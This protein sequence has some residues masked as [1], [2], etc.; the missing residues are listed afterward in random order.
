MRLAEDVERDPVRFQGNWI[1]HQIRTGDGRRHLLRRRLRR[2]L[3]AARPPRASARRCTSAS[4]AAASCAPWSRA[5]STKAEALRRYHDFS[6]AHA[7][8]FDWL[9]RVQWLVPRVPPRLLHLGLRRSRADG[10]SRWAFERYLAIA[11]PEF[12]AGAAGELRRGGPGRGP[13][14]LR[15]S[16]SSAPANGPTGD[17]SR[18]WIHRP[19]LTARRVPSARVDRRGSERLAAL[20]GHVPGHHRVGLARAER[21]DEPS[22]PVARGHASARPAATRRTTSGNPAPPR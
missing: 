10:V 21:S 8:E 6:A 11:P 20:A 1:P 9:L 3:R 19:S 4:P 22:R 16:G 15:C 7:L 18:T 14:S 5:G 13:R 2:S 12:V 17:G